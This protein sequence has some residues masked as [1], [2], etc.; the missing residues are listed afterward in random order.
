RAAALLHRAEDVIAGA[1]INARVGVRQD[2]RRVPVEPVRWLAARRRR[3]QGAELTGAQGAPHHRS[4]LALEVDEIRLVWIG[5]ADEAVAATDED[6]VII[7]RADAGERARGAAPAAV[8]LETAVDV[9]GLLAVHADV[10]ELADRHRVEEVP[11]LHPVARDVQAAIG[12][13]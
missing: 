9:I 13:E 10:I 3:A 8:V 12:T 11:R 6:P 5:P 2:E 4:I 1:V 7:P